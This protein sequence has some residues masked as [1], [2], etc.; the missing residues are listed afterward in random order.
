MNTLLYKMSFYVNVKNYLIYDILHSNMSRQG[1][2]GF[3]F[4]VLKPD[5]LLYTF[6]ISYYNFKKLLSDEIEYI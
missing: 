4:I 6:H 2:M 1:I 5:L 3:F